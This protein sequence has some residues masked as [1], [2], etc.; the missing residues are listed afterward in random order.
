MTTADPHRLFGMIMR[1]RERVYRLAPATPVDKFRLRNGHEIYLKREDLSPVHSY[2][3][4]GAYNMMVSLSDEERARG[5]VAASAGNHAQGVA[6]SARNLGCK[7]KVFMPRST[8]RMKIGEVERL[9]GDNVEIVIGGDNYD[10]ASAAAKEACEGEHAT[11]V[12][13]YDHLTVMAGQGTIGDELVM[14]AIA[15][16]IAF[17]QIGGGGMAASVACVLR[18]YYPNIHIVGVEG[19]GQACMK[20]AME[21]GHPVNLP[22]V[23]VFCDGTAVRIAGTLTYAYCSQLIDEFMT[24]SNNEVCAGI[25]RLWE[26]S[27]LIAEP[28]GAMGV[29]AAI[30]RAEEIKGKRVVTILSGANMDFTQ[31]SWIARHAGI[32]LAQRRY[33]RFEIPE[34]PGAMLD[35]LES[36]LEGVNIIDFQYGKTEESK[37]FPVIGFEASPIQLDLMHR[38][39]DERQL[40]HIDVTGR[41]DVEFR[42]IHY[43]SRMFKDPYFAIVEFP[44]RAG[45]LYDFMRAAGIHT[46]ICYF[47]YATTGEQ[48]GRALMGFEFDTKA[49]RGKFLEYLS[50]KGPIHQE[51]P[52]EVLKAIL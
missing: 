44:E 30:K 42:I 43:R 14:S 32:G 34:R 22:S 46:N 36:I 3:W 40:S 19:E 28:S 16:E 39:M 17:L 21:K 7:A 6:L 35:L 15:P 5:V 8:P 33:Y 38:R 47:N 50:T 51:L 18:T 45:A 1:A 49:D 41:S 37:A 9:G 10:E 24:V 25:Q 12:H 4:R 29:A 11:F 52:E 27:R 31:L 20:A 48:V 23:D 13:P 26:S 2:K